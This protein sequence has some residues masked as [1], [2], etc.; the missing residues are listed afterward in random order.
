MASGILDS[1]LAGVF[2]AARALE[3]KCVRKESKRAEK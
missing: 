3:L 1:R 2:E